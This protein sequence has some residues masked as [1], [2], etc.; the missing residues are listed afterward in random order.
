[1]RLEDK[2]FL[3]HYRVD[4]IPHIKIKDPEAC[5]KC[6]RHQ[7]TVICPANVYKWDEG[8]RKIIVGWEN[9]LEMG[10]CMVACNEFDNIDMVYPRGGYGISYKYG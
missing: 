10:A 2:L 8:Q 9:C 1:M 7:C 3:N 4:S 5:L 6:E